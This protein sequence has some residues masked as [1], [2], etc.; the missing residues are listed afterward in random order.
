ML[1]ERFFDG[2]SI[3]EAPTKFAF[4]EA[5]FSSP[6]CTG[7]GFSVKSYFYSSAGVIALLLLSRPDTVFFAIR[8]IIVLP[9]KRLSSRLWAHITVEVR[10]FQP[11]LRDLDSPTA[12]M[13]VHRMIRAFA[14]GHHLK[15][16]GVDL[17]VAHPMLGSSFIGLTAARLRISVPEGTRNNC[18][19]FSA[20]ALASPFG[21]GLARPFRNCANGRQMTKHLSRKYWN[22]WLSRESARIPSSV[23]F[24]G[25]TLT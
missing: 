25:I 10:E 17:T 14:A 6:L 4:V 7:L 20:N 1:G 23:S 16:N 18:N 8:T 15:P 9:L 5:K 11:I 2:P 21:A 19:K 22:P 3:G 13:V 24:H 12:V